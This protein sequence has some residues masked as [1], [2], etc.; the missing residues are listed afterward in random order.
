VNRSARL[1]APV[2]YAR[3]GIAA[4]GTDADRVVRNVRRVMSCMAT[5]FDA[6]NSDV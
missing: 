2:A 1:A 5:A 3:R 4:N 6:K